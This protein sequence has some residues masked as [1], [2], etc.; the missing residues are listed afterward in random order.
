[1]N[2]KNN[3][4]SYKKL[5]ITVGVLLVLATGAI[6]YLALKSP[7][8]PQ[9]EAGTVNYTE[10]TDEEKQAAEDHKRDIAQN[11]DTAQPRDSSSDKKN[12]TPF[13]TAWGQASAGSDFKLNGFVPNVIETDGKCT[14][15]MTR[16]DKQATKT[17]VALAD[18]KSTT[19]GQT[20]IPYGDLEPGEW[21]AVL[22][23]SSP[24]SS[25]SSEVTTVEVK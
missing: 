15:T 3:R 8:Q 21:E 24:R 20:I 18:A 7:Q 13:I 10:A 12:V 16:G 1:M 6:T 19:C 11:D 23:Y 17:R 2:L 9:D 14:L 4:H 5:L 25:G 22:S